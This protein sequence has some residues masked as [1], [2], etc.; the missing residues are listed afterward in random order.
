MTT[1]LENIAIAVVEGKAKV[2]KDPE[3]IKTMSI[4]QMMRWMDKPN[5]KEVE[6]AVDKA[7]KK[8]Q[9]DESKVARKPD[10]LI[11]HK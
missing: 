10:M 2:S 9:I 8:L 5:R 6:L 3:K 7:M 1:V 11:S 4:S